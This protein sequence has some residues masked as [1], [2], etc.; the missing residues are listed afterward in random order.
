MIVLETSRLHLAHLDD[1]DAAFMLALLNSPG[2]LRN[3]GDR[4]VKSLSAAK[5]YI[6]KCAASYEQNHR[7]TK[8]Y[9]LLYDIG[10][11][12]INIPGEG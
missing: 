1:P 2:W 10:N 12:S 6:K 5:A 8:Y 3:I 9:P 7:G 11:Q 4:G